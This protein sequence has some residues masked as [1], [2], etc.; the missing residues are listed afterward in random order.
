MQT[1]RASRAQRAGVTDLIELF[2]NVEE[3]TKAAKNRATGEEFLKT[4]GR[5][6]CTA[7]QRCY[8]TTRAL[9]D[10]L[11]ALRDEN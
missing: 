2:Q 8:Y 4:E 1:G 9:P 10:S 3:A 7:S 5:L 6:G 11:P